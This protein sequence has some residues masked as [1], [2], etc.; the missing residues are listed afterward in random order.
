MITIQLTEVEHKMLVGI[1]ERESA[2]VVEELAHSEAL[3]Y[4]EAFRERERQTR[5]LCE[6]ISAAKSSLRVSNQEEQQP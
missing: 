4:R 2:H 6:K 3:T 1:L 5:A